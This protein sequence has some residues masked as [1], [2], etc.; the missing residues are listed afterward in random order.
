[1]RMRATPLLLVATLLCPLVVAGVESDT[2]TD[3]PDAFA[4]ARPLAPGTIT[5]GLDAADELDH[6][7]VEP[8]SGYN[9]RATL[10][11]SLPADHLA[12]VSLRHQAN[13]TIAADAETSGDT[14]QVAG[15][16]EGA[17]MVVTVELRSVGNLPPVEAANYTLAIEHVL[18]PKFELTYLDVKARTAPGATCSR[19]GGPTLQETTIHVRNVGPVAGPMTLQARLSATHDASAD[20]IAYATVHLDPGEERVVVLTFDSCHVVG[21]VHVTA[22]D[23][24]SPQ[25]RHDGPWFG[26]DSSY[27]H[28][29]VPVGVRTPV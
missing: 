11:V 19:L 28:L 8:P 18:L 16:Y 24:F 25:A 29:D 6:F 9:V 13:G 7:L 14:V 5:G 12:L 2:G 4:D 15:G 26:S 20:R 21:R 22:R 23:W 10:A 27:S 3:A 17:P 1:M